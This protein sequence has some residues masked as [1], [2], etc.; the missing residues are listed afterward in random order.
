[1]PN[2]AAVAQKPG[3][4]EVFLDIAPDGSVR[5]AGTIRSARKLMD[6]QVFPTSA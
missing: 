4:A 1:L 6:G 2:W 5:G 3:S